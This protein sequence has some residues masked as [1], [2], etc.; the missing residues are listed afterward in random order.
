MQHQL[1]KFIPAKLILIFKITFILGEVK[2]KWKTITHNSATRTPKLNSA[3][4]KSR[5]PTTLMCMFQISGEDPV[6]DLF[7]KSHAYSRC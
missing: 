5:L 3:V 2:I 4:L 7:L 6:S 1:S